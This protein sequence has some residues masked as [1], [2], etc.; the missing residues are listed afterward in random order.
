MKRVGLELLALT[1][2]RRA[3]A[4]KSCTRHGGHWWHGRRQPWNALRRRALMPRRPAG[5]GGRGAS[6]VRN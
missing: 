3:Q 2:T 4:A 1:D 5:G 6:S